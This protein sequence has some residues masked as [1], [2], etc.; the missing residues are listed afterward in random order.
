[1]SYKLVATLILTLPFALTAI[2]ETA[3]AQDRDNNPPGPRG[4]PGTNWENPPGPR[5]GPDTSPDRRHRRHETDHHANRRD[6]ARR[7]RDHRRDFDSNPPGPRGGPGTN[8]ENPPGPRGGPGASPDR[9]RPH[10]RGAQHHDRRSDYHRP[11]WA[12]HVQP[13]RAQKAHRARHEQ[14]A[15]RARH[16]QRAHRA[17]KARSAHRARPAPHA[18]QR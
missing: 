3:L 11:D 14:R 16:E 1:M 5:G 8:W 10:A 12:G 7:F 9:R 17:R 18:R 6:Q 2:G 13:D 4:G 15:H